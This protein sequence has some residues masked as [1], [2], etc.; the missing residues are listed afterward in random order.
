VSFA[1]K[2]T[3]SQN[4]KSIETAFHN[5]LARIGNAIEH[6]DLALGAFLDIEEALDGTSFDTIKQDAQ[7][8][9]IEPAACR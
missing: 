3:C 2:P 6:K 5:V 8:H 7:R 9:D 1:L 4:S